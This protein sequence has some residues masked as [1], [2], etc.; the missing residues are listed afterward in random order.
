MAQ[1]EGILEERVVPDA[2]IRVPLSEMGRILQECSAKEKHKLYKCISSHILFLCA[3]GRAIIANPYQPHYVPN[4]FP[5]L[6]REDTNA[7]YWKQT[8]SPFNRG[9]Q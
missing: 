7:E 6:I 8:L 1:V 5:F 9:P 4:Y 3:S 2:E